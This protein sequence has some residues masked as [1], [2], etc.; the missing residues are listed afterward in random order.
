MHFSVLSALSCIEEHFYHHG[1]LL[2][3]SILSQS[4]IQTQVLH[5]LDILL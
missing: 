4:P 2:F 1:N 5:L 3:D